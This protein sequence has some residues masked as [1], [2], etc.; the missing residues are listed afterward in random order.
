MA[1]KHPWYV[2]LQA[3]EEEPWLEYFAKGMLTPNYR[4]A[5]W[6]LR[7]QFFSSV[8]HV[9]EAR[10]EEGLLKRLRKACEKTPEPES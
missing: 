7:A 9:F 8:G 10:P 2:P 5:L 6:T 3:R 4:T 1:R